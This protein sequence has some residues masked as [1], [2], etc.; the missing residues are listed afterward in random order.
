[1]DNGLGYTEGRQ[2]AQIAALSTRVDSL[3]VRVDKNAED[4][5]ADFHETIEP[6]RVALVGN[7][8]KGGLVATVAW[9]D[10]LI[11]WGM[12]L[13]TGLSGTALFKSFFG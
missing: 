4:L 13:V 7:D 5:K 2:D 12:S 1:M 8:S 6:L 9:H 10:K 11:K 3:A